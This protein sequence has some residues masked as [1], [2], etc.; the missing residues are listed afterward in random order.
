MSRILKKKEYILDQTNN[1]IVVL[2]NEN[3]LDYIR[4]CEHKHN[5]D[6]AKK[7]FKSALEIFKFVHIN[8]HVLYPVISFSKFHK[9]L[10]DNI[11]DSVSAKFKPGKKTNLHQNQ[12]MKFLSKVKESL[13]C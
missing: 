13:F 12:L 7:E 4:G 10:L 9:G 2:L 8:Q 3:Q 1:F 11:K 6:N 5:E